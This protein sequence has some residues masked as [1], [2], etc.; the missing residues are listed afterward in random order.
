LSETSPSATCNPTDTDEYN[1]TVGLP[2]PS[3]EI[4]I[5]DDAGR[6]VAL[7]QRGEIAI[8]G[9]QVMAGY[10]QHPAETANVM[11]PDGFFKSGDIEKCTG[12]ICIRGPQVM[13]GYWQLPA[14]TA[15]V[16][17]DG[18]LKTGDVGH[19]NAKG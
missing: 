6:P 14:E 11:T 13:K 4:A 17:R 2:M 18:W 1:G 10:W 12:E 9:P 16:L 5:L 8:R 15:K 3:T 19:I 7:G